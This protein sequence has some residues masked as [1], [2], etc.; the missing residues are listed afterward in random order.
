MTTDTDISETIAR[1]KPFL[2]VAATYDSVKVTP[3]DFRTLIHAAEAGARARDAAQETVMTSDSDL[4]RQLREDA[5][6]FWRSPYVHDRYS[7]TLTEAADRIEALLREREWR[8]IESAPRDGTRVLLADAN[9]IET[10]QWRK[11]ISFPNTMTVI[12]DGWED[13]RYDANHT[14]EQDGKQPTHWLPLPQPPEV[15]RDMGPGFTHSEA[16][17]PCMGGDRE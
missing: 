17:C 2:D 13:D 14:F 10:G 3:A 16:D 12:P 11:G 4:V 7:K 1:L 6:F 15:H 9:D 8:P 5:E